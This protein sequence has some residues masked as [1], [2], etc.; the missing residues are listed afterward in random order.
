MTMFRKVP[1]AQFD[2]AK[3]PLC[4]SGSAGSGFPNGLTW[5]G[6]TY[7]YAKCSSCKTSFVWPQPSDSELA[8]MY[9]ADEYHAT[10]YSEMDMHRYLPQV[11]VILDQVPQA[12]TLLDFG[13]GNG[14][15]LRAASSVGFNCTGAEYQQSAADQASTSSKVPVMTI[16]ELFS[17]GQKFDVIHL[18]DVIEH[19]KDPASIIR[20]LEAHLQ[21]DGYFVCAGPLE[22]GPSLV[23]WS[24]QAF[25]MVKKA[26]GRTGFAELPPAHLIVTNSRA[27]RRFFEQTLGHSI[28][29]FDVSENGWPY[30]SREA[31][32]GV[33][34]ASRRTIG[35]AAQLLAKVAPRALGIG[36]RFL[37]I[38][39]PRSSSQ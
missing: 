13:C 12:E 27:Q 1:A 21:P 16:E 24:S 19:L 34:G 25:Q 18:G 30:I 7:C 33:R 8:S 39:Q 14:S 26:T 11:R 3:C 15:F 22:L 2:D 20:L 4:G 32:A 17:G 6:S 5:K 35:R 10:H 9:H 36:N 23:S 37:C 28:K 31:E 38:S 29:V